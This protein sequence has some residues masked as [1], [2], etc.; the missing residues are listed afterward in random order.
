MLY[1]CDLLK[2]LVSIVGEKK[3]QGRVKEGWRLA[4]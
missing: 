4:Q 3:Q 1:F 2:A